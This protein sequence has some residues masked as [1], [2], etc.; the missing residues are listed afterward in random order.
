MPETSPAIDPPRHPAFAHAL[1]AGHAAAAAG[2]WSVAAARFSD[3]LDALGARADAPHDAAD[4]HAAVALSNLG[5]ALA[6]VGRW[7]DAERA[8]RRAA[9]VRDALVGDG[10]AEPSVA[11]RGWSDVAALLAAAGPE[12]EAREALARARALLRGDDDRAVLAALDETAALVGA[13]AA[14]LST[15][16]PTI[17]A[18]EPIAREP[19]AREPIARE[20]I[21]VGPI[22]VGAL[23]GI[24]G[25]ASRD[26]PT[27][28][29]PSAV[30]PAEAEQAGSS[31]AMPWGDAAPAIPALPDDLPLP[32]FAP[33]TE[34]TAAADPSAATMGGSA[35]EPVDEPIDESIDAAWRPTPVFDAEPLDADGP[36]LDALLALA[37]GPP[38]PEPPVVELDAA[39]SMA[40]ALDAA[41]EW[42]PTPARDLPAVVAEPAELDVALAAPAA[43]PVAP[44]TSAAP[45]TAVAAAADAEEDDL[46]A[47]PELLTPGVDFA[48]LRDLHDLE[49]AAARARSAGGGTGRGQRL[50][51]VDA[52]VELTEERQQTSRGGGLRGLLRRLT[53]R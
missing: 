28:A 2:Q 4:P 48:D 14:D 27:P 23:A 34:P 52:I 22:D 26:E 35:D 29:C 49:P 39:D 53:G 15:R 41:I 8:L 46:D 1:D 5:Q 12:E 47:E 25:P 10:L 50:A 3:A 51:A 6:R 19:I 32:T 24:D 7:G 18:S 16:A 43:T 17:D 45:T 21:D 36:D 38:E 40:E 42:T 9:Q 37:A 44:E 31:T 13:A 11:A 20:P 30:E 33:V